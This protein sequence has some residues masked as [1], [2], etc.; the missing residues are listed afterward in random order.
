MV[1]FSARRIF[2][3]SITSKEVIRELLQTVFLAELLKSTEALWIVSPWISNVELLDNSRGAFAA[4]NPEWSRRHI[5]LSDIL[6]HLL[7]R[8]TKVRVVTRPDQHNE[9]FLGKMA[10]RAGETGLDTLLKLVQRE[11]LH[12]K[13]ILTSWGLLTGSMNLTY[14]G[15]EINDEHICYETDHHVRASARLTFEAYLP[16]GTV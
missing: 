16:G 3:S 14:N 11:E 1:E 12:T 5:R 7:T 2:R 15:V 13:G 10:E 8:G 4:I 9:D 6:V